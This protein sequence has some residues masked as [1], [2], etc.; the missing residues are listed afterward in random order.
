MSRR[1]VAASLTTI[2]VAL[3]AATTPLHGQSASPA[4]E[5]TPVI[6]MTGCVE[7]LSPDSGSKEQAQFVLNNSTQAATTTPRMGDP[8]IGTVGSATSS[9]T[10][11]SADATVDKG[12]KPAR[13]ILEG[14]DRELAPHVNHR[15]EI[16]A[17]RLTPS[18][19]TAPQRL[20][21]KSVKMVAANCTTK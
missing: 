2:A 8:R 20:R 15:V 1:I 4:R 10:T 11:P 5:E 3:I 19:A 9:N 16:V 21:V 17:T 13:Y 18:S 12:A 7:R 6:S 14:A